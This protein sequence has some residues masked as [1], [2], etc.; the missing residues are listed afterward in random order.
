MSGYKQHINQHSPVMFITFDGDP[1]DSFTRKLTATPQTIQD[2][3]PYQNN[4]ILHNESEDY[5]AYR[6]GLPSMVELEPTD[7][8]SISFG[9]YGHQPNAPTRWPKAF[10][11]VPHQ[12]H[13]ALEDNN[14]SFTFSFLLNKESDEQHWRTV[15]QSLGGPWSSSLVR[16][17]IRKAGVFYMWYQ[18]NW[19]TPDQIHITYPGGQLT[20]T[21]E[22]W[23]YAKNHVITFTWHVRETDP[24]VYVGTATFY[25]NGRVIATAE[26]SYFDTHP[27]ST[28][29]APIEIA[30]TINTGGSTFA[31]RATT[32]TMIDQIFILN[33]SLT[34]DEVNRLYKKARSY[35]SMILH[36]RPLH[37]WPMADSESAVVT[38]M[39]DLVGT[40][41]GN[42]IGGVS[43]VIRQQPPP[44]RILGGASVQFINGGTAV[45]HAYRTNSDTNHYSPIFNP[46]GNFAIEFW[47]RFENSN[48]SVLFSMQRDDS[49]YSGILV[50]ANMRNGVNVPG[51]IQFNV[52]QT[53]FVSSRQT[54][55]NGQ[56]YNFSDGQFHH[57]VCLRRGPTIELWIDGILHASKDAPVNPVPNPGP[58]QIYLMG[59]APGDLNTTG[60]MSACAVY[61]LSLDPAEIRARN[62]YSQIYRIRGTVTLQGN[63]HQA[64]V[65]AI[66][67]RSGNLVRE[68]LSDSNTGDYT[69]ELY[70][71]SLIDLMALNKQDRN[72]RYRVY[73][74]ITP[75]VFDDLP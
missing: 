44:P 18:D 57:F 60:Y 21:V 11:E 41:N 74:P 22:S 6:M 4:A 8:R 28:S 50:Q 65:R 1:Y 42:Y 59:A 66:D 5:P 40:R 7:Q 10:L 13:L 54:R 34:D 32:N 15:E 62:L 9:W 51:H 35:D 27:S 63:P 31:D 71:N 17:L 56:P 36:A 72:I 46:T 55:D 3:T 73:G 53:E 2:E 68:V 30:G 52:S 19:N 43:Q 61:Q 26:H 49:P 25:I 70:N 12:T 45:V 16:P 38:T 29:S 75:S 58:G 48:R 23:L 20:W 37:Y 24:N 33:K 14:G 64:T 67:H 39:A 47:A 69:I